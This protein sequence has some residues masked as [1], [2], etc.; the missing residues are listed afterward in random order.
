MLCTRIYTYI[1]LV[2]KSRNIY[3]I[4]NYLAYKHIFRILHLY[5]WQSYYIYMNKDVINMI[6][7]RKIRGKK[8]Y[9]EFES[10]QVFL[11]NLLIIIINYYNN[12]RDCNLIWKQIFTNIMF[13]YSFFLG[14]LL[15]RWYRF[16]RYN[17]HQYVHV[18]TILIACEL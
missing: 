7:I 17:S 9:S 12:R 8:I 16:R 10:L 6:V 15:L 5:F 2:V 1:C 3:F 18:F 14:Y 13:S 11:I 4:D